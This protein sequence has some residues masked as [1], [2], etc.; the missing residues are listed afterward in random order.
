MEGAGSDV[1]AGAA[2]GTTLAAVARFLLGVFC[3][4]VDSLCRL[5][6]LYGEPALEAIWFSIAVGVDI[7]ALRTN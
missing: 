5:R 7:A 3:A 2:V 1:V 6:V 4:L